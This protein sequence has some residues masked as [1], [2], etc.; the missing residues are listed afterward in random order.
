MVDGEG[1]EKGEIDP[2]AATVGPFWVCK[3]SGI[4]SIE[5]DNI[6]HRV[7]S[8]ISKVRQQVLFLCDI[9]RKYG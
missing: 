6:K 1:P 2:G 3:G 8:G 9:D 5:G 4:V 7:R